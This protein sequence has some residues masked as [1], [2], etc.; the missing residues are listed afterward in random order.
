MSFAICLEI[1]LNKIIEF[2]QSASPNISKF[3]NRIFSLH[4]SA[5]TVNLSKGV[6]IRTLFLVEKFSSLCKFCL[7]I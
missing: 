1:R 5:S 7:A 2:F 4:L 3:S 6:L